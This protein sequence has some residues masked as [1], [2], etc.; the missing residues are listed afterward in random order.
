MTGKIRAR[1]EIVAQF[2][3]G[4]TIMCGGFANHG[5]PNNLIDCVLESGAKNLTLISN[6][7]GDANLTVG[8]LVHNKRVD[9]VIASHVGMNTE[10]VALIED[11]KIDVQFSPQGTLMERI[12]CGGSGLGGVL[13]KTGLGT[14][15]QDGKQLIDVAG[16]QYLL[17]TALRADIALVRSRMA[18]PLGNLAYRGTSRNTN[19]LIAQAADLAI[20]DADF[21]VE[22]DEIGVDRIVTPGVF[23]DMI[24]AK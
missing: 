5:V 7:T 20:V 9:R 23:I 18:D 21:L 10:T 19:A 13:T 4:Q 6:D 17:E 11:G 8:R 2:K 16:E 22:V 3:D 24:L 1:D 15:M 12:R 14:I